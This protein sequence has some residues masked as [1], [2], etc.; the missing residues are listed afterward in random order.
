MRC[1]RHCAA[2]ATLV[3]LSPLTLGAQTPGCLPPDDGARATLNYAVHLATASDVDTARDRET[4]GVLAA[5]SSDVL[6][7]TDDTVCARFAEAYAARAS[8]SQDTA[9]GWS[10]VARDQNRLTIPCMGSQHGD[11]RE[12]A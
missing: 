9:N 3:V 4:Y 11:P 12:R 10:A 2:T 5:D 7:I 1:V 8:G 6:L